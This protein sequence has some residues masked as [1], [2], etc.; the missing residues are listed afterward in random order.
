MANVAVIAAGSVQP[1]TDPESGLTVRPTLGPQTG[2][3]ALEQA[4]LELGPGS[5]KAIDV[6]P[7]EETLFVLQGIGTASVAGEQHTL[8]PEVGLYL[9]PE[10]AFELHNPGPATLRVVAVRVPEPVDSE[11]A[12]PRPALC[13][14]EDSELEPAT[15][16]RGFR[17]V[18]DPSTGLRSATHF[19]GYIPTER[20]P[21]HFHTYEEVIYVLGGEG[22][23]HA[24]E[25]N[26]PLAPGSCIQLPARTVHCLENTGT[27]PMRVVAV[28][29]PAGS[30]A[31]AY[32]PD[33]APAQYCAAPQSVAGGWGAVSTTAP[34]EE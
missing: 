9:P 21:D 31:A 12:Q 24:G 20:A 15:A 5:S 34:K 18:A 10:S 13:R 25:I 19:V 29:R 8:E 3:E 16:A 2:F 4:V 11:D 1:R 27:E 32:Y 23:L 30:P 6:G 7:A 28:F 33:G 26:E 14:L 22:V 17:I